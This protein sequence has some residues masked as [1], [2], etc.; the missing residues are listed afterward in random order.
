MWILDTRYYRACRHNTFLI[1]FNLHPHRPTPPATAT[2]HLILILDS[3]K[4]L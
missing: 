2:A 3:E 1:Q 4:F